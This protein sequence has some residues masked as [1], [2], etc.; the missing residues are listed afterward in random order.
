MVRVYYSPTY[1]G[2]AYAFETTRKAKWIAESLSESP[3]PGIELVEP[4]PLT[5]DQVAKVHDAG[6]IRAIETGIPRELAESQDLKWDAGLWPMVLA[7][8]Q[9]VCTV[10]GPIESC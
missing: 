8:R 7:S 3:I 4:E 5:R 9:L 6:Y 10:H 2:A 1:V